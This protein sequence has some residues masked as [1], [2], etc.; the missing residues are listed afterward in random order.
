[1][2]SNL[3]RYYTWHYNNNLAESELEFK[4]T[5]DTPYLALTGELSWGFYC[6][7]LWEYLPNFNNIALQYDI[8]FIVY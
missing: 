6:E 4:I 8:S 5:T 7:D 1:M 2:W 3:S